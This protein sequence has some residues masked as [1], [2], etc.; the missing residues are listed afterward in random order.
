[1]SQSIACIA[2][3]N[4]KI[5]IAKRQNKGDM[6]G[7]WEFPGGKI[8]DG[9]KSEEAIVREMQ[10]EFGVKVSVGQKIASGKFEH[11]GKKCGL[12]VF[13][14]F[15][16]HDGL[17]KRFVLTEHDDYRWAA[18]NEIP[19]LNFVDSDLAVYKDVVKWISEKY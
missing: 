6:G 10:E 17:E 11:G 3:K 16:P 19:S 4:G 14:I 13:E 1:M 12:E 7:R 2:Y 5:F 8:E 18:I 9:E 15:L